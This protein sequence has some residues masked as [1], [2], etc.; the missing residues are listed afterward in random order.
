LVAIDPEDEWILELISHWAGLHNWM[1][2]ST[3]MAAPQKI[4]TPKAIAILKRIHGYWYSEWSKRERE[5]A[6]KYFKPEK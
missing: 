6:A 5:L 1:V 2:T 4:D 3:A